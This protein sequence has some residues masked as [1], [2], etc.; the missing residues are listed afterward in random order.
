MLSSKWSELNEQLHSLYGFSPNL[1]L[2]SENELHLS[3]LKSIVSD[4]PEKD[5]IL[6]WIEKITFLVENNV[7]ETQAIKKK[8]ES[9]TTRT[10]KRM[11]SS[12]SCA[13]FI[14][15][16]DL[17]IG[18]DIEFQPSSKR[19]NSQKIKVKAVSPSSNA[20]NS[21]LLQLDR[22]GSEITLEEIR[23]NPSYLLNLQAYRWAV[24]KGTTQQLV[25]QGSSKPIMILLVGTVDTSRCSIYGDFNPTYQNSLVTP[26]VRSMVLRLNCL[27]SMENE[28]AKFTS[29]LSEIE[30]AI[31]PN[32]K[33]Q[34][35]YA[36]RCVKSPS[37]I[38]LR[39]K[40]AVKISTPDYLIPTD[41]KGNFAL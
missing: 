31:T 3:F 6:L 30:N 4:H 34:S 11:V 26:S 7:D 8:G 1:K 20:I 21:P 29:I 18:Q 23:L 27:P 33:L 40:L 13:T 37:S 36:N 17:S 9:I 25:H 16:S 38:E 5:L 32:F 24:L 35:S 41:E 15:D 28:W 19:I 39:R 10:R 22:K 12:S 14:A 2:H